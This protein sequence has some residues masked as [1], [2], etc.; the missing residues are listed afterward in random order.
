MHLVQSYHPEWLEKWSLISDRDIVKVLALNALGL[1]YCSALK[2]PVSVTIL[3]IK[4][5]GSSSDSQLS[6]GR[7]VFQRIRIRSSSDNHM[8]G[9]S[10]DG[11]G[12]NLREFPRVFPIR[13]RLSFNG[14]DFTVNAT[15]CISSGSSIRY[16]PSRYRVAL[17]ETPCRNNACFDGLLAER[18]RNGFNVKGN[19]APARTQL[20]QAQ[21]TIHINDHLGQPL[22][23]L[24]SLS[25]L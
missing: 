3:L 16:D 12:A 4:N 13:M 2:P 5:L 15:W 8:E 11:S 18:V 20:E 21:D 19:T 14:R 22:E 1:G 17:R 25:L 10:N 9:S 6:F 24:F 23:G 7:A